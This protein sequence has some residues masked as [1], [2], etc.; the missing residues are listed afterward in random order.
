MRVH[1]QPDLHPR[2][3]EVVRRHLATRD[4]TPTPEHT[5]RAFRAVNGHIAPAPAPVVFDSGCGTGASTLRL[6][7]HH[8]DAWVVGIDKSAAR[9]RRGP[10]GERTAPAPEHPRAVR[11]APRAL[12]VRADMFALWRLAARAGLRLAHHYVLYPNPWPKPG[13]LFRRVHGHPAFPALLTLGGRLEVRTN[14]RVYADELSAALSVAGL[15]APAPERFDPKAPLTPFEVKYQRNGH[16]LWR[17]SADL[18]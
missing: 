11:I 3:P 6:A 18:R 4:R 9:L 12:L 10:A 16:D 17:L 15:T 14:W 5:E 2:L 13:H 7:E 1:G 8:P